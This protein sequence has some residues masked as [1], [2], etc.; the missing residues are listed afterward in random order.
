MAGLDLI[1]RIDMRE[2]FKG[3]LVLVTGAAAGL[4]RGLALGFA[5]EGAELVL[6]DIEAA[7]LEETARQVAAV[8]SS[9]EV[10][11]IN[12]G[13]EAAIHT[14]AEGFLSRHERLDVLINNAGLAYGEISSSFEALSQA[15]WLRYLSINT[16]APLL[17]AQALRPAL[18]AASG[19]VLNQSSMAANVPATAYGVTKA[20]LN[21]MTYGMATRFGA[22]GIRVNAVAPGLMETPASVGQLSPEQFAGIRKM[23]LLERQ[24]TTDD[25]VRLHLFLASED[26]SFITNEVVCCDGGNTRRGWRY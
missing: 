18:A 17:L 10:H 12:L 11:P 2:R 23:Q 6:L 4:G 22:D 25:I 19:V 21:A 15:K 5:A 7:G 1:G 3:K 16:V 20:A 9:A 26:A 24:G 8:G 14:F 13:D